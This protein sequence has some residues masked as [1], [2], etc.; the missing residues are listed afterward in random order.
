MEK[1]LNTHIV[2][3]DKAVICTF[4]E[5]MIDGLD[6]NPDHILIEDIAHSLAHMCRWNGHTKR[7]Y[8]VA[9][10]SVFCAAITDPEH[11]L[12]A[13]MHDASEAYLADISSPV[14]PHLQNYKKIEAHLMSVIAKKFGFQYPFSAPVLDVDAYLLRL[15]WHSYILKKSDMA[16]QVNPSLPVFEWFEACKNLFLERFKLYSN[17]NDKGTNTE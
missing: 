12:A 1:V 16:P 13:L 3:P 14:K 10:H 5:V 17:D 6:P 8:S 9:E 4:N 2:Y 11:K 7:F 15:E